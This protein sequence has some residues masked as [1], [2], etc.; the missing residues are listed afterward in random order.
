M[1][2]FNVGKIDD[3]KVIL[4]QFDLRNEILTFLTNTLQNINRNFL[5]ITES[6]QFIKV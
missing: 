2:V 3:Q 5:V 6:N 4:F 1:H